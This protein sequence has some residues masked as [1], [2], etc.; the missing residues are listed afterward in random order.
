MTD[1]ENGLGFVQL[2]VFM[3]SKVAMPILTMRFYS[4]LGYYSRVTTTEG[5]SQSYD[6]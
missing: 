1:H 4:D 2:D 5:G 3:N 6:R